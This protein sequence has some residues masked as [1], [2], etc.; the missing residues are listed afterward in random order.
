L[1]DLYSCV[2][3]II[4][5]VGYDIL[6]FVSILIIKILLCTGLTSHHPSPIESIQHLPS[7]AHLSGPCT[8]LSG[9]RNAPSGVFQFEFPIDFITFYFRV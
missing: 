5:L 7:M 9:A 8:E 4:T 6:W 3:F 1:F 2:S